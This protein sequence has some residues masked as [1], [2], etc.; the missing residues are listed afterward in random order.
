MPNR[1]GV[2]WEQFGAELYR[3]RSSAGLTQ[4]QLA[5]ELSMH[6]TM[7]GKLERVDRIPHRERAE[8]LDTAL[9]A[10][11]VLSRL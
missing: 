4:R 9:E 2:R 10:G 11:G 6:Y 5:E 8:E 7:V 3:L 1:D